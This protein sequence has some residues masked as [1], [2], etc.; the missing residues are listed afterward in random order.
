MVP[1]GIVEETRQLFVNMG[2]VLDA[3]GASFK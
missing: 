3:A 1:G 2:H